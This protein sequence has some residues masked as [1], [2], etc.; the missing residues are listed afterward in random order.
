MHDRFQLHLCVV[1]AL[2][3]FAFT[4]CGPSM[5]EMNLRSALR[6]S[7]DL[8]KEWIKASQTLATGA[9]QQSAR[10][11][12]ETFLIYDMSGPGVHDVEVTPGLTLRAKYRAGTAEFSKK[13]LQAFDGLE[14]TFRAN[15]KDSG[16]S[17]R[18]LAAAFSDD[19]DLQK[20][21]AALKTLVKKRATG[22]AATTVFIECKVDVYGE[23]IRKGL[24]K[25]FGEPAGYTLVL[26]APT[27]VGER[28]HALLWL[29]VHFRKQ[30][31]TFR[32]KSD[33]S[34]ST[35]VPVALGVKFVPVQRPGGKT[36]WNA[37]K[38]I[39]VQAEP[40]EQILS[41]RSTAGLSMMK[42][43]A[44]QRDALVAKLQAALEKLPEFVSKKR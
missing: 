4:G 15:P 33:K 10:A 3:L 37:L 13:L 5:D 32:S 40:P 16:R 23:T 38:P 31:T 41:S 24:A 19:Q 44:E 36:S 43:R 1:I 7:D 17:V 25:A 8:D 2:A 12:R 20:R 28:K 30:E 27:Q 26:E 11:A 22:A 6:K 18:T 29:K 35:S 14:K 21:W 34:A 42:L 39:L 9:Y